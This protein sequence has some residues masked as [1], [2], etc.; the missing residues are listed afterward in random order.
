MEAHLDVDFVKGRPRME[1]DDIISPTLKSWLD[2]VLV[3]AMVREFLANAPDA[4]D[5]GSIANPSEKSVK[6]IVEPIQ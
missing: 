4:G 1:R 2:S 6:P 5:N 3:P